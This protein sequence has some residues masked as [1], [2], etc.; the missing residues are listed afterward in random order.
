MVVQHDRA[1]FRS[2]DLIRVLRNMF[3]FPEDL[4]YVLMPSPATRTYDHTMTSRYHLD[5]TAADALFH[6]PQSAVEFDVF[7]PRDLSPM[8]FWYSTYLKVFLY[9]IYL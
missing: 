9:C 2:F 4:R 8:I 6:A 7:T 5:V 3:A 1:F